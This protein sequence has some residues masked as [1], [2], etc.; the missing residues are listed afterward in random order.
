MGDAK[1]RNDNAHRAGRRNQQVGRPEITVE[2]T[3]RV[4]VAKACSALLQHIQF[5]CQ[6][7][8][9]RRVLPINSN[10]QTRISSEP[11]RWRIKKYHFA[12]LWFLCA[13]RIIMKSIPAN[14]INNNNG[15]NH[16]IQVSDLTGG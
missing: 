7:E 2:N 14:S 12:A 8:V 6:P 9:E 3:Q 13:L 16:K 5:P 11:E 15:P 4:Q 1:V 10:G